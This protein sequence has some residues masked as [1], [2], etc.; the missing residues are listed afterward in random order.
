VLTSKHQA[1]LILKLKQLSPLGLDA[2][3]QVDLLLTK[4]AVSGDLAVLVFHVTHL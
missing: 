1:K 2:V 4:L 3:H